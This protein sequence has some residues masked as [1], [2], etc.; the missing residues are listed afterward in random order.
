V[1]WFAGS[2]DAAELRAGSDDGRGTTTD[3][4]SLGMYHRPPFAIDFYGGRQVF[5]EAG[6]TSIVLKT[7]VGPAA[8]VTLVAPHSTTH[9]SAAWSAHPELRL[10]W[11]AG[12]PRGEEWRVTGVAT[13]AAG[14]PVAVTGP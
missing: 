12:V 14:T 1:L 3:L 7:Y 9:G 13:N 10:A 8:T 5:E 6:G 11:I 4:R 2:A